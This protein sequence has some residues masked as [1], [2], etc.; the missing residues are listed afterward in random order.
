M[1]LKFSHDE[2]KMKELGEKSH[3]RSRAFQSLEQ[4]GTRER[5]GE[6]QKQGRA[7]SVIEFINNFKDI[8]TSLLYCLMKTRCPLSF[9]KSFFKTG[10]LNDMDLIFIFFIFCVN[11]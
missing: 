8:A 5:K 10:W 1:A 11:I 6:Q 7:G 2:R 9:E 3:S 4:K